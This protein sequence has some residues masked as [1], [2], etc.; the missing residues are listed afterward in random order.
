MGTQFAIGDR[1]RIKSWSKM[2]EEYGLDDGGDIDIYPSFI[3][4]MRYLCGEQFVVTDI[5]R[6]GY[7]TYH[8]DND[9]GWDITA[10]ML[11]YDRDNEKSIKEIDEKELIN[12]LEVVQA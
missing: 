9:D 8:A 10:E 12:L 11:E 2:E 3:S 5:N 4:D 1:L 7:I 6:D